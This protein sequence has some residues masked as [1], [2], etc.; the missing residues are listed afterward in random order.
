MKALRGQRT[1]TIGGRIPK[2]GR[3]PLTLPAC[4]GSGQEDGAETQRK[5]PDKVRE[6][7]MRFLMVPTLKNALTPLRLMLKLGVYFVLLLGSLSMLVVLSPETFNM[8]PIGGTDAIEIAEFETDGDALKTSPEGDRMQREVTESPSFSAGQVGLMFIFLATSLTGT[9]LVM[10]PITWTYM[11]TKREIGFKRNFVRALIVLPICATTI[12]LLIQDSLALAFG[13]AAM[14]A[15]VRF[16]VTLQEAIDGIYIFAAICVGL[17]AGIGYLGVGIVMAIFFCFANAILWQI[18]YGQNPV[19][20]AKR[21][22]K[23]ASLD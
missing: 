22:R 9:I 12:V 3:S 10:L 23:S 16:R 18:D 13:L 11:S 1:K 20:D 21:E 14:V 15:A 7:V 8:L 4:T 2:K 17:A 6:Q 5:T 19:D